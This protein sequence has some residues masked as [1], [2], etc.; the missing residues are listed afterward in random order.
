MRGCLRSSTRRLTEALGCTHE[1]APPSDE[2]ST[3]GRGDHLAVPL[4]ETTVVARVADHLIGQAWRIWYNRRGLQP[5]PYQTHETA[6]GG[7]YPDL[8]CL[9]PDDDVVAIEVK[10]EGGDLARGLG[11]ALL[12]CRGAHQSFLAAP[13]RDLVTVRDVALAHGIGLLGVRDDG[14]VSRTQPATGVQP[15]YLGD[16]RRE[17][18]ILSERAG[19]PVRRLGS[20]SLS[21]NHPLHYLVPALLVREGADDVEALAAIAG[22]WTLDPSMARVQLNGARL[23]GLVAA[24]RSPIMLTPQGRLVRAMLADAYPDGGRWHERWGGMTRSGTPLIDRAPLVAGILRF[25]YLQDPDVVALQVA[26]R[27]AGGVLSLDR[28]LAALL[29]DAPNIA[30]QLFCSQE[31]RHTVLH[32]LQLGRETEAATPACLS[33]WLM[34][35]SIFQLKRQLVHVGILAAEAAHGGG[36]ATYDATRDVWRLREG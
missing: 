6:I 31:G 10:R 30:L 25:L 36:R 2:R 14:S 13:E 11:Q 33:S 27:T 15:E 18:L 16:V 28:L 24:V 7:W 22:G 20:P 17:L 5:L 1:G 29:R 26:L 8:L 19:L 21:L 34:Q 12:Y 3:T 32:L 35:R 4:N 9:T 23:L